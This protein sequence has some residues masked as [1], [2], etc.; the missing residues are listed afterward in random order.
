MAGAV[1]GPELGLARPVGLDDVGHDDQQRVGVGGLRG[2]QRLGGLAE[3]GL[4]GE[5]EGAVA[6]RGGGDHLRLVRHQLE[7]ARVPAARPARAAPCRT[8]PRRRRTR[9]TRNSGPSSSQRG[10][11]ARP[12][13]GA[14]AALE[15]SGAR[16]GLASWRAT[17][18][19]GTTRRSAAAGASAGSGGG[20]L[21][22]RR[23]EPGGRQHLALE[24]AGRV[25]DHGVLGEQREQRGVAGGG[26]GQDRGDRRR[27]A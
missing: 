25:G 26:L 1:R 27:A 23:L 21:L 14:A 19:C 2:E 17:T 22:G 6:G 13:P 3:A 20:G 11:P 10:Q 7:A 5:Q 18:D 8:A 24:V 12:R 15:K 9:R 16:N 4:V